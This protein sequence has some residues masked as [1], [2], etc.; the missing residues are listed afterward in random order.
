MNER[1]RI[2]CELSSLMGDYSA[3]KISRISSIQKNL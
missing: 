3:E 1:E 2:A